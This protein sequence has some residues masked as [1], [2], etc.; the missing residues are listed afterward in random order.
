MFRSLL[1]GNLRC[2]VHLRH[3]AWNL[4]HINFI[5][6][7]LGFSFRD[8]AFKLL[9]GHVCLQ[10]EKTEIFIPLNRSMYSR[11]SNYVFKIQPPQVFGIKALEKTI[12]EENEEVTAV[13]S[14]CNTLKLVKK[15]HEA[16]IKKVVSKIIVTIG[17]VIPHSISSCGSLKTSK[18]SDISEF[19]PSIH[20]LLSKKVG[21]EICLPPGLVNMNCFD[22]LVLTNP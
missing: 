9:R 11:S 2:S 1:V 10:P 18:R 4:L 7:S 5:L 17:S 16:S 3:P 12:A 14:R 21:F 15:E 8:C 13:N 19:L 22:F 6:R 20:V